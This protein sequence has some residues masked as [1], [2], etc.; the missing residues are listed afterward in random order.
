MRTEDKSR[1]DAFINGLSQLSAGSLVLDEIIAER[2]WLLTR[3]EPT[4][5]GTVIAKIVYL[6]EKPFKERFRI[7]SVNE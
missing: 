4:T 6:A 1:F 7:F 5:N 2:V 3:M